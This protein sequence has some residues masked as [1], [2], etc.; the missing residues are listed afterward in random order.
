MESKKTTNKEIQEKTNSPFLE[1]IRYNI[2]FIVLV[3]YLGLIVYL[4]FKA[5]DTEIKENTWSRFLF[6]FSGIEVIVLTAIG[7]VFGR[8]I[9]RKAET[10]AEKTAIIAHKEKEN[11]NKNLLK[12]KE[13][14]ISLREAV[15]AENSNT[16]NDDI[17][18]KERKYQSRALI[19]ALELKKIT[20]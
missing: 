19:L 6:L 14:A 13:Q 10:A 1:L 16:I 3:F 8:N 12:T 11:A 5:E 4:F 9:S 17:R 7:Y 2:A 15:I 18:N 20:E